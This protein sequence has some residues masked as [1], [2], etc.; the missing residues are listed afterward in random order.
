MATLTKNQQ[1]IIW[2]KHLDALRRVSQGYEQIDMAMRQRF[3]TRRGMPKNSYFFDQHFAGWL[4]GRKDRESR[5][6]EHQCHVD[7]GEAGKFHWC[8]QCR[9]EQPLTGKQERLA[10]EQQAAIVIRELLTVA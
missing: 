1:D 9:G 6:I 4:Y 3:A 8:R 10:V 2:R 5:A 7:M